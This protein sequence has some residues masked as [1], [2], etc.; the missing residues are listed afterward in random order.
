[1]DQLKP[2][3]FTLLPQCAE[4]LDICVDTSERRAEL[5]RKMEAIT[6]HMN[7]LR[8]TSDQ[9]KVAEC[10]AELEEQV[11]ELTEFGK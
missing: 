4:L 6:L 7:R 11:N 1:M 2:S 5:A 9:K 3:D 10:Q 8:E